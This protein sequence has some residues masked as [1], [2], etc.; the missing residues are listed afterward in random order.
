MSKLLSLDGV[1][2]GNSQGNGNGN[3]YSNS[4]SEYYSE[5]VVEKQIVVS[6]LSTTEALAV[7]V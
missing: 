2:N 3:G 4:H 6:D 1:A 7:T 5:Q